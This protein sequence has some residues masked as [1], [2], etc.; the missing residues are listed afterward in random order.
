MGFIKDFKA[1]LK[2]V[3]GAA[4]L[5]VFAS[6]IFIPS[7]IIFDYQQY[8]SAYKREQQEEVKSI[9]DKTNS[10]LETI[11]ELAKLTGDY[12]AATKGDCKEIQN[13]LITTPRLYDPGELP[14]IQK[15]AYY[16]FSNP[17]KL[18]TRYDI[19][20][21]K[22]PL[23]PETQPSGNKALHR[24]LQDLFVSKTPIVNSNNKIEGFLQIQTTLPEFKAFLGPLRSIT[25][26]SLILP[27]GEESQLL[28]KK[29]FAIYAKRPQG[30]WQFLSSAKERYGIFVFYFFLC[31]CCFV[32]GTLYS[33]KNIRKSY[34]KQIK[35]LN[36]Q[37][38]KLTVDLEQSK[39]EREEEKQKSATAEE[40]RKC[41]NTTY[42]AYKTIHS[43]LSLRQEEQN[44]QINKALNTFVRNFKEQSDVTL[45]EQQLNILRSCLH[46][47]HS[48]A[49]G[50]ILRTKSELIKVNTLFEETKNLFAEKIYTSNLDVEITCPSDLSFMGDQLFTQFILINL[51]GRAIH[52]VPRNGSITLS[53]TAQD[54][55]ALFEVRDKGF[56]IVNSSERLIKKAFDFLIG[57]EDFNKVCIQNGLQYQYLRDEEDFNHTAIFI[58]ATSESDL[59]GNV[60][61]L[62]NKEMELV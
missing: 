3:I 47:T 4:S 2:A 43:D 52:R 35:H 33:R 42:N 36:V 28:Q 34:E 24:F 7:Y 37:N 32:V 41:H 23:T 54:G 17:S 29:P 50:L 26:D 9:Q 45:S 58:P 59:R 57:E 60:V 12:I 19:L 16:K 27:S 8:L 1:L 10:L 30:L 56:V 40:K 53:A 62:F 18:I 20:P 11:Q 13:I 5:L 44:L 15:I 51:L 38:E 46:S 49:N 39:K 21:L 55:G 25:F 22:S 31:I 48:L 14:K 61:N 6:L